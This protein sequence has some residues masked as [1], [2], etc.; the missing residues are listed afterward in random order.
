MTQKAKS[1][2]KGKVLRDDEYLRVERTEAPG[3]AKVFEKDTGNLHYA[4]KAVCHYCHRKIDDT[5]GCE[6]V[7][8][9]AVKQRNAWVCWS[10]NCMLAFEKALEAL[11]ADISLDAASDCYAVR[12]FVRD[13]H[14]FPDDVDGEE[15][16]ELL[17]LPWWEWLA[18]R[19]IWSD[20]TE[21]YMDSYG[22]DSGEGTCE[23]PLTGDY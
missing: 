22:D 14:L 6:E 18:E 1:K 5:C 2:K 13:K 20:F 4:Y 10:C 19:D 3:I 8:E 17:E 16:K 7:F 15:A 11:R 9:D 12:E 23:C 21:F